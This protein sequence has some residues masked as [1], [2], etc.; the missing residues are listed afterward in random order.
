MEGERSSLNFLV[1][2]K[3]HAVRC[4]R[5]YIE[6]SIVV[7]LIK[8]NLKKYMRLPRNVESRSRGS[9]SILGIIR[10]IEGLGIWGLGILKVGRRP[11]LNSKPHSAPVK[12]NE[13]N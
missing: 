9:E 11:Q 5:N 6:F 12:L 2:P 7:I 1:T 3:D 4:N 13:K 10:K 8:I